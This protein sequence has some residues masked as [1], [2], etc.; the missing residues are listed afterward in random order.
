VTPTTN[1]RSVGPIIRPKPRPVD[2]T[3][4]TYTGTFTIQP[5]DNWRPSSGLTAD[6]LAL[7]QA[8]VQNVNA[9]TNPSELTSDQLNQ[10]QSFQTMQSI[11]SA[12]GQLSPAQL[13]SLQAYY[14]TQALANSPYVSAAA[15]PATGTFTDVLS[16]IPTW[17]WIVGG[18]GLIFLLR[19]RK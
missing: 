18:V 8:G 11:N 1:Y 2:T 15:A 4:N 16:A 12:G 14:Q 5:K 7:R 10:L 3:G 19:G 13:Q 6:Q 9:Y 17:A